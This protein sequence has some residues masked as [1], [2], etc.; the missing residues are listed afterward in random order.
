[1]R[2]IRDNHSFGCASLGIGTTV[3]KV[4]TN[5]IVHFG[6]AG[7]AY[8]KAVTDDLFTLAGTALAANQKCA[9]FLYLDAAGA[10][11]IAQSAI[12]SDTALAGYQKGAFEWPA[13]LATKACIGAVVVASLGAVFTPG[14]TSLAGAG[15]ATYVNVAG[16]LG[17]PITY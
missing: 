9:F 11:S 15:V 13:E 1:M 3:Q 17:V 14:T 5:D 10:A 2:G 4:R 7:R 16:D 12:V 6:I 8:K